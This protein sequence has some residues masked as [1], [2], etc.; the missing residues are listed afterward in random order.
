MKSDLLLF[1]L[2]KFVTVQ[3]YIQVR[4]LRTRATP[5]ESKMVLFTIHMGLLTLEDPA[6]FLA[7][8][9]QYF[10]LTPQPL[11]ARCGR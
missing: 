11:Q 6:S 2:R 9:L 1:A 10:L 8:A 3:T 4:F 5:M 7:E